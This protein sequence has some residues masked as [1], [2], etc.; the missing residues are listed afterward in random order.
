MFTYL[1]E[2]RA[3]N[4]TDTVRG[5]V[6]PRPTILGDTQVMGLRVDTA[7]YD[8]VIFT[9]DARSHRVEDQSLPLD[10]WPGLFDFSISPGG[11]YLLYVTWVSG[12]IGEVAVIRNRR[13]GER[14]LTGPRWAL[15][16]CDSDDHHAHWVTADSFEIARGVSSRSPWERFSGSVS[17]RSV[18]TD[19]LPAEPRWH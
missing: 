6:P 3:T 10:A 4:S 15:C 9:Y 16:E 18:H 12:P 2:I 17:R 11:E 5:V 19:T 1:V 8:R 7:K 14:V 13:S